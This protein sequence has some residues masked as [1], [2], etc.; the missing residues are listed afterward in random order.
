[1]CEYSFYSCKLRM[2]M[3]SPINR[4]RG[5]RRSE[6]RADVVICACPCIVFFSRVL[7]SAVVFEDFSGSLFTLSSIVN[8]PPRTNSIHNEIPVGDPSCQTQKGSES[9]LI[10]N[11]FYL[12]LSLLLLQQMRAIRIAVIV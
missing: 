1:M 9:L 12:F 11:K 10:A 4:K 6:M 8:D 7:K 3:I 2:H 5:R